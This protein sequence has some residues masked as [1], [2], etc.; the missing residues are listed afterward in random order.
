MKL[1]RLLPFAFLLLLISCCGFIW[2]T[3][4]IPQKGSW[5]EK[6]PS[7]PCQ[8]PDLDTV[9]LDDG[10]ARDLGDI[11]KYHAGASVCFRSYPL[12]NT[13]EGK[14]GQ[15]CCYDAEGNLIKSGSGAGTPDRAGTC[16]GEDDAGAMETSY[17]QL[18]RHFLKDVL[19][20]I[21]QGG[22]DNAWK[23]YNKK[24]PPNQGQNCGSP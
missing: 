7:C 15:Q 11:N 16:V 4:Q 3:A 14:S 9:Q 1:K 24:W 5:A 10:W 17:G 12:V 13:S 8:S 21:H 18:A 19:P 6:L 23:T 2:S 20:W 22:K